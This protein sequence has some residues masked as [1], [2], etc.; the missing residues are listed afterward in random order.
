MST[1]AM[2]LR[3]PVSGL[4][5]YLLVI[6]LV[7][8]N[9]N[10]SDTQ[11]TVSLK[12]TSGQI[13]APV[14]IPKNTHETPGLLPEPVMQVAPPIPA[15]AVKLVIEV[16]RATDS[17]DLDALKSGSEL[18]VLPLQLSV[19]LSQAPLRAVLRELA[20]KL[21]AKVSIAD[22]VP[23]QLISLQFNGV[24]VAEGIKQLLRNTNYLLIYKEPP[25][26][27][28]PNQGAG[29]ASAAEIAEIRVLPKS[30]AGEISG[31]TAPLKALEPTDQAA[32]VAEWKKQALTAE[33]LEDRLI[34]LKQF[35]EHA[36]PAEHNA[37]LI[38]ALEDKAP[39]VRMLAL[40]SMGDSA[41]PLLEPISQ[42]A[43]NDESPQIRT[44]ALDVLVSRYG[45]DAI[46]VLE[47][48]LAD[49]DASVQQTARNS[50]EMAQRVKSQ[51][52]AML[53]RQPK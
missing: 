53:H 36:D 12:S 9:P 37:V 25:T 20:R 49:S 26:R 52:D 38:A 40:N 6:T 3:Q 22:S 43:L 30:S 15:T 5:T 21:G 33:K 16:N 46:P 31:E 27:S 39:E 51:I 14:D 11:A 50:L 28:N 44:A 17:I 47:Q 4:L 45:Q 23:D 29:N 35:L 13:K 1:S 32:E 19:D 48:A 34:A 41:N 8:C 2:P 10:E 18:P 7:G 24:G 42:T